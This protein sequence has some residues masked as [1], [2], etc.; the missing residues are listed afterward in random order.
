[1][2]YIDLPDDAAWTLASKANMD[3]TQV[4]KNTDVDYIIATRKVKYYSKK[5][6]II[7]YLIF[8]LSVFIL[9]TYQLLNMFRLPKFVS[10]KN[11][12]ITWSTPKKFVAKEL[13]GLTRSR[14]SGLWDFDP[15]TA[16]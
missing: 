9:L 2:L 7:Y 5:V 10:G 14:C 8:L 4:W 12:S 11:A 1:M 13:P 16:L 15:K 3:S 6:I